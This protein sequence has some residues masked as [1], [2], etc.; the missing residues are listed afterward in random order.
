MGPPAAGG[1]LAVPDSDTPAVV[2]STTPSKRGR[3]PA[4]IETTELAT[5]LG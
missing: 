5:R 4:K 1:G 3:G 2:S